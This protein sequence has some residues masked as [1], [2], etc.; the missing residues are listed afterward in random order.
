MLG[1]KCFCHVTIF[2]RFA[3]FVETPKQNII[4][5]HY[6]HA[7]KKNTM[8][9]NMKGVISNIAFYVIINYVLRLDSQVGSTQKYLLLM[10]PIIY[11]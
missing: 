1:K 3:L 4:P 2:H 10:E 6:S 8:Y 5:E 9:Y 11:Q 7:T